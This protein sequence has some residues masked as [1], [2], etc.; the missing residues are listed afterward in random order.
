V[1]QSRVE[2]GSLAQTGS[3]VVMQE[4]GKCSYIN[5]NKCRRA[6]CRLGRICHLHN[7]R[8]PFCP[9]GRFVSV[10]FVVD[11]FR[12]ET[13][14]NGCLK[15]HFVYLVPHTRCDGACLYCPSSGTCEK[16]IWGFSNALRAP[17]H[18]FRTLRERLSKASIN[19]FK[20]LLALKHACVCERTTRKPL[21]HTRRT[22]L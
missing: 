12:G 19:M 4:T 17:R 16:Q 18:L 10:M 14:L 22:L 2:T 21:M 13:L 9:R 15:I 11:F 20:N 8:C 7:D 3:L 1:L 6:K 5:P